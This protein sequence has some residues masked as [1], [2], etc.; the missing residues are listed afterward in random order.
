MRF[1][2]LVVVAGILCAGADWPRFRG[3]NGTGVSLDRGLP[4]ELRR[5]GNLVWKTPTLKGNSSPIVVR[6]RLWITGYEGDE[7]MLMCYDARSG[8]LLWRKAVTK[9]RTETPHPLNGP[10]TPTPTTD[11]QSIF[12]FFP[13]FGLIAYAWDGTERWRVPLGPFGGIQGMAVSPVYTDGNVVLLIDTPEQAY[14]AAFNAKTGKQAWKT[15][16]PI[17]FLGSYAT[18]S[19]YAA[20][21]GGAQII[22][23]GA[24]ELTG[25]QARTGERLWWARG[26]TNGPAV[27]PLID[28]DAVY[29]MEPAGEGAPPFR[30]MAGGYDKNKDG[31]VELSEVSGN[32][33]N[34][35]IMY[36]L[37]RSIDKNSGN[38]D[39]TVSE[40]E[41]NRAFGPERPGGGLIR[42][43]LNGKGDVSGSHVDWR[44]TKGLPYVTAPLLYEHILYV[45]RDGGILSTFQPES[46][47]LLQQERLKD[48][49]GEYYA[50]PVA[51]DGKIYFVN[52]EG[53]VSVVKAG[54]KWELLSS[55]DLNEQVIATPAIA[56][57]RVYLRTEG[58]LYCFGDKA[59]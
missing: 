48:G 10:T 35:Q 44:Q 15:D 1:I 53:R 33:V 5:D 11:G 57:S 58:T 47:K 13:E 28:G 31:L 38:G 36:R 59:R 41:Y 49:A 30:N 50:Q 25:Y 12:A 27:L 20:A 26:V 51:G 14:L 24:V 34:D 18:P 52:K 22:V 37:F 54:E 56:E 4:A 9:V 46:G 42:T 7:R 29:T 40:E 3:P 19:L 6:G 32:S 17:G 21:T 23:A 8:S 55:E 45:I 39:G 43:R 2:F 16:R